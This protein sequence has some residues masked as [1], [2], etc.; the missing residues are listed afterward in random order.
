MKF[1]ELPKKWKRKIVILSF[2]SALF[3]LLLVIFNIFL[4]SY[5][6]ENERQRVKLVKDDSELIGERIEIQRDG[7]A[8]VKAN[9]YVPDSMN[10]E[11]LPV[12]F[13]IHGGGFVGGDADVLDTQSERIANEWNVVVVTINYTKADVKPISYGSEEIRDVVLYFADNAEVYGVDPSK[14]TL[15]GYSA[16]AYYA[17]DSTR[18]LQLADFDMASLVLCYPWTTGLKVDK[19]EKDFPPTLFILSGQDPISQKAKS[20][21]KDMESAGL[22]VEVIEYENAVHSFIES[23]NPEGMVEGTVDM[24]DVINTEQESLAREAEAAISEWIKLR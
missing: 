13:N 23:N 11:R 19:L 1:K 20:Y 10:D 18:L 9:L 6:A 4:V 21:V 22:E 8:S 7:T 3:L 15:M 16:G 17:A 5:R 2:I 24:S 12:V 14:F